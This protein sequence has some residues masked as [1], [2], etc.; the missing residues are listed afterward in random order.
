[1]SS[2][3]NPLGLKFIRTPNDY[4]FGILTFTPNQKWNATLNYIF[5]GTMKVPHFAGA[6]NQVVDEIFTSD[7]FS[8]LSV[9]VGH[10]IPVE[11]LGLVRR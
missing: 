10:K 5:T 9:K 7:S 1:M 8:E 3:C 6:P 11:K 4:A 2:F